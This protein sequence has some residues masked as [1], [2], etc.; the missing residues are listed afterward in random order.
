MAKKEGYITVKDHK[1]NFEKS[2]KY[3]LINPAKS[4]LDKVSKEI[5]DNINETIRST[6]IYRQW[7]N[8]IQ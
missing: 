5:L 2:P 4:E 6:T 8:L 3:R 1:E 7:K